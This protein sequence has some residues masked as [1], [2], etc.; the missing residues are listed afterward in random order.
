MKKSI[1]ILIIS[2][3][4]LINTAYSETLDLKEMN[5]IYKESRASFIDTYKN[6]V[7][8]YHGKLT[9]VG[10]ANGDMYSMTV[11][12]IAKFRFDKKDMDKKT[13]DKLIKMTQGK[14]KSGNIYIEFSGVLATISGGRF[15]FEEIS[16]IQIC[17]KK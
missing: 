13:F 9:S 2:L 1:F 3:F 11:A 8:T 7:G 16:K 6:Q 15:T 12:S 14:K 4:P 5:K 17:K 10:K